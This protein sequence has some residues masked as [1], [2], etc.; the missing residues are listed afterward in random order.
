MSANCPVSLTDVKALIEISL[1]FEVVEKSESI[2][3]EKMCF[4][5]QSIFKEPYQTGG[6]FGS[7]G[8]KAPDPSQA[9][10]L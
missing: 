8:P 7:A 1:G 10:P 6:E 5:Y 4:F 9:F 3:P 2:A